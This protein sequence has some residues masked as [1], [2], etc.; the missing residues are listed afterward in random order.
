[1]PWSDAGTPGFLGSSF[2]PFK[3]DDGPGDSGGS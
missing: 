3:P 1:M 2:S